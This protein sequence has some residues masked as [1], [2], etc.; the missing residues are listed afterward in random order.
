MKAFLEALAPGDPDW[1]L[2]FQAP[3]VRGA[4]RA[5]QMP[6]ADSATSGMATFT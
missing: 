6:S 4:T 2:V 1:A 5:R 3:P